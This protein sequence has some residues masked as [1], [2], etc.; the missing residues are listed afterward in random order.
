M[1]QD[2]CKTE[3]SNLLAFLLE[4]FGGVDHLCQGYLV[5]STY[6]HEFRHQAPLR[7]RRTF[8]GFDDE[9]SGAL[10]V[11]LRNRGNEALDGP[12]LCVELIKY[13]R[14]LKIEI[15]YK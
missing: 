9:R 14:S 12:L 13:G 5:Y 6:R 15:H 3:G 4:K 2:E 8:Q 1:N 10:P 7:D 11:L